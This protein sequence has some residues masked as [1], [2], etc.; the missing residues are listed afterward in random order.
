[1]RDASVK[2]I[3]QHSSSSIDPGG[4]VLARWLHVTPQA[5]FLEPA[6]PVHRSLIG[7]A[8]ACSRS[9]PPRACGRNRKLK[10]LHSSVSSSPRFRRCYKTSSLA[11]V[12]R[13]DIDDDKTPGHTSKITNTSTATDA[14]LGIAP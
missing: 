12:R 13:R 7:A 11:G 8:I 3:L 1:M 5:R 2:C 14:R 4:E 10:D 6:L 9:P